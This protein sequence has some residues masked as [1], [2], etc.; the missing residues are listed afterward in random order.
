MILIICAKM[1]FKIA[2]NVETYSSLIEAAVFHEKIIKHRN[3]T[4]SAIPRGMLNCE[5]AT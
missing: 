4:L 1:I 3:K 2:K 5:L